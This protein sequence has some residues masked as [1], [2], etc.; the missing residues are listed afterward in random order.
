MRSPAT[1]I[2]EG[3]ATVLMVIADG[4]SWRRAV[5][6]TFNAEAVLPLIL[7]MIHSLLT[8][9]ASGDQPSEIQR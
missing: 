8:A 7:Q 4:I 2:C 9:N 1:S 6:P 5:D 3:A